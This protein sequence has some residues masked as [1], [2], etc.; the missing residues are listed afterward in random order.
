MGTSRKRPSGGPRKRPEPT[1]RKAAARRP[2]T[3]G[4]PRAAGKPRG[5][6]GKSSAG[7]A[8][9]G[10]A[11]PYHHGDL[12]RALLAATEELLETAGVEAFTLREVARRAG[13]SHGAPAHHFGDV[14]GLLSEFTAES[15]AEL[16]AAMRRRR[17][18]APAGAFDQLR[19]SGIAYVE[20]AVTH[21]A[22][23][24]LMFRSDRLDW[25]RASLARSSAD[26]FGQF[27]ECMDR[28][29]R[30]AGAPPELDADKIAL[31]WSTVHGFATLLIDN[32]MFAE[33]VS[34]G[35]LARALAALGRVLDSTRPALE[36][37]E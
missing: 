34:G 28:V 20:Y 17:S 32:R 21:R 16:A 13:V 35:E 11:G 4:A 2:K 29:C 30:E 36:R 9:R 15:F 12:R 3:A 5:A 25:N 37:R 8:R 19:A 23:F 6:A 14:Q 31:A 27:V 22:R 10:A 26:A 24:Q 18:Q 33:I 1:P 7:A